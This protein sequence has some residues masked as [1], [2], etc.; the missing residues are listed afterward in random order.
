[1]KTKRKNN[2]L[3]PFAF[4]LVFII[5][6]M[7][8]VNIK[9]ATINELTINEFIKHLENNEITELQI[10]TKVRSENYEVTGKLE[11]YEKNESFALYLP[12]SDE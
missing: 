10:I 4:L 2:N 12:K 3:A 6:C 11:D 9:G 7:I 1:M 8:I 5:V